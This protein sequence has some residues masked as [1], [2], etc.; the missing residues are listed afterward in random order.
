MV[1][2][3]TSTIWGVL[4]DDPICCVCDTQSVITNAHQMAGKIVVG[5]ILKRN[6][7]SK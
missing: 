4:S 2:L 1:L 6:S 7:V 3:P 5:R